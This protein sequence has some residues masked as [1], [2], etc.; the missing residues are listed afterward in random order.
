VR[1]GARDYDARVGRW[2]SR[3]PIGFS[4]GRANLFA[5]ASND[6]VGI[7]DPTGLADEGAEEEKGKKVLACIQ[8]IL[9]ALGYVDPTG[10]ADAVN[11]VLY[12]VQ[13]QT[14]YAAI[15]LAAMVP[16]GDAAKL[17]KLGRNVARKAETAAAVARPATLP[18][19]QLHGG[20]ASVDAILRG[21]EKWLGNGYKEIAPGVYRSADNARQFRMK[22]GDLGHKNPHVHFE[23]IADDGRTILENSHVYIE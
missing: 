8:S 1:F 3:D 2:T 13:G 16:F 14:G 4:G 18:T 19:R 7:I 23:A 22:N 9:D 6:P 11:A 20:R 21:A 15:S 10:T 17:G 5:Y 12:L